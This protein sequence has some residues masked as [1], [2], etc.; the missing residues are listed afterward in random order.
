MY[1]FHNFWFRLTKVRERNRKIQQF[2]FDKE[3]NSKTVIMT[4]PKFKLDLSFVAISIVYK[5]NAIWHLK[6]KNGNQLG[7]EQTNR[8]TDNGKT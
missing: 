6:L 5:L 2:L 7:D 4:Q 8:R 1:K 3:H